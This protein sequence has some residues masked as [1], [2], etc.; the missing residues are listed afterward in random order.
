MP[1]PLRLSHKAYVFYMQIVLSF[2]AAHIN[3]PINFRRKSDWPTSYN[4]TWKK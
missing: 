1:V 2:S 4:F 3:K